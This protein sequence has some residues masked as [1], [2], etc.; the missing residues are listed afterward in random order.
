MAR[1]GRGPDVEAAVASAAEMLKAAGARRDALAA[2]V[3]PTILR[4]VVLYA[5]IAAGFMGYAAKPGGRF[6]GGPAVT[7]ILLALAISLVMELDGPHSGL[8]RVDQTPL[9]NVVKHV[10]EFEALRRVTPPEPWLASTP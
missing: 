1:Q 8:I 3:P 7:F 10:R 6:I 9:I 2:R 5:L 4:S